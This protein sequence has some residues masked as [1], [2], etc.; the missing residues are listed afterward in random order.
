MYGHG[1]LLMTSRCVCVILKFYSNLTVHVRTCTQ[2]VCDIACDSVNPPI[3]VYVSI[4]ITLIT[5]NESKD[6]IPK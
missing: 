6:F 4:S 1:V 2:I 3:R 5:V